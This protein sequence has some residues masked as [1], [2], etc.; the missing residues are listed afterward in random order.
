M[1][2]GKL[3]RYFAAGIMFAITSLCFAQTKTLDYWLENV[4]NDILSTRVEN[5]K[6]AILNIESRYPRLSMYIME[7]LMHRLVLS[8]RFQI[9]DKDELAWVRSSLGYTP[10]RDLP[11]EAA[12]QMGEML[13]ADYF[14]IGSLE[15]IINIWR[16]RCRL[17]S[18]RTGTVV[19]SVT[20]D[21]LSDSRVESFTDVEWEQY[22]EAAA[23]GRRI[24]LGAHGGGG[25][26][27]FPATTSK[28]EETTLAAALAQGGLSVLYSVNKNLS[29][30]TGFDYYALFGLKSADTG[31]SPA[32]M[33]N[34]FSV[35][36]LLRVNWRP[37]MFLF[38]IGGGL[39]LG[40]I[41]PSDDVK[42]IGGTAF[43]DLGAEFEL[44][45]GVKT[46]RGYVV[47]TVHG[48]P[49]FIKHEWYVPG[50]WD[51]NGF[52]MSLIAGSLGY[53]LPL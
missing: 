3:R 34:F 29:L 14:F 37:G 12:R 7:E 17:I 4:T 39:R 35:P 30:Q 11:F 48:G 15:H 47:L 33:G 20:D 52:N 18:V 24:T 31:Y 19:L 51:S 26:Q 22:T 2:K 23:G 42:T 27:M 9:V 45:G 40:V 13:Y 46:G 50:A 32:S 41:T 49:S 28:G 6:V 25:I 44:L 38:G 36:V 5:A 21:F 10:A 53:Q 43:F 16:I 8:E 1:P